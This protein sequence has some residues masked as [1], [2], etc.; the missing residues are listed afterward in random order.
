[1]SKRNQLARKGWKTTR[2]R[3][4][5]IELRKTVK[6]LVREDLQNAEERLIREII[7]KTGSIKMMKKE[8]SGYQNLIPKV[9]NDRGE[10]VYGREG[11][12]K[13]ATEFYGKLY[14]LD[15]ESDIKVE[16]KAK[17]KEEKCFP[18][19][20]VDEVFNVLAKLKASKATG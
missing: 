4:E 8:S 16:F 20:L 18:P 7:E 2:E 6:K 14:D 1:M 13:I 15:N 9:K 3:I 12:V 5:L 11:I 19:F 10:K 17:E